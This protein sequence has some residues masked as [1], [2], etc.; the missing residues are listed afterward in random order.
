M[1]FNRF[2]KSSRPKNPKELPPTERQIQVL[3]EKGFIIP[4][5]RAEAIKMIGV[6]HKREY[7]PK[8]SPQGA[9]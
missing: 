1:S 5:T 7:K 6:V 8:K 3:Q 9:H 4:K 2:P